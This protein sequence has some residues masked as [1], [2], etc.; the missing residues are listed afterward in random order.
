[1]KILQLNTWTGRV[2]GA[3]LDFIGENDFDVICLQETVWSENRDM[4]EHFAASFD[5]IQEASKLEFSSRAAN[6]SVNAF[7]SI[8]SEGIGVL[9]RCPIASET[10]ELVH[11]ECKVATSSQ[12][13]WNHGYNAQLI[14]LENGFNIVNYHGYW[15]P[16]PIG[17]E[18]TVQ[19]MRK[20][21]KFIKA[22]D[23][24]LIMCGDLNVIHESPAMRELD[25]L[26]DL[27]A[28]YNIDNTLSGL[29][30]NGK[31]ACDHILVNDY[32]KVSDFRVL[33]NI[34]SDHKALIAEIVYK[35]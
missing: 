3:L 7:D 27:T 4:L 25:F 9:S 13:L 28:K 22:V 11:G 26:T 14:K 12:E 5:Q 8:V 35:G 2:K 21:A 17:D 32:V 33:E 24:P 19:A 34:V 29:K 15:L 31:V 16:T 10:I 30:F 23:G 18:V 20:V 1:M 6:W